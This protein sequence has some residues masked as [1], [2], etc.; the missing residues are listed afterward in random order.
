MA[1]ALRWL[2]LASLSGPSILIMLRRLGTHLTA[3]ALGAA[4]AVALTA[5]ATPKSATKAATDRARYQALDAFAQALSYIRTAYVDDVDERAV[6][7]GGIRGMLGA[8]DRHSSFFPPR[9]YDR[10]RQDT[11][12]EFGGIGLGL[13]DGIPDDDAALAPPEIDEV[14][15]GSPA[16][17]AGLLRGDLLVAVDGEPTGPSGRSAQAWDNRL[18]GASGT[19]VSVTIGRRGWDA[20]KSFLLTRALIKVP[21]IEAFAPEPGIGYVR[22]RRFDDSTA[23]DLGRTLE[24]LAGTGADRVLV[25]DLRGNP[26]GI[27]VQAV[28]VADMFVAAGTIVWVEGKH[29]ARE[30]HR[31]TGTAPHPK[32]PIYLLVDESTASSAEILAGALADH[33]RATVIGQQTFGK[34]SVQTFLPLG[35]GSGVKLTSARYQTPSGK[36]IEGVGITPQYLVEAFAEEIITAGPADPAGVDPV[37]TREPAAVPGATS[38]NDARMSMQLMGDHQFETAI[39]MARAS[40]G[41]KTRD[42]TTK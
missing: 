36:S 11:E 29:R 3:F 39:Q 5:N 42:A 20:P 38:E 6:I 13:V 40:L 24:R 21:N 32:L 9:S 7:Y 26:G 37:K 17:A 28:A 23:T 18:R 8:L 16:A 31:A 34:G 4:V 19:K 25:L 15:G 1:A 33:Q 2:A 14:I 12:G 35:D 22:I 10:L 30:E 41:S 27:V